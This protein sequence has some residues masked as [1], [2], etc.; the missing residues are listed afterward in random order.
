[1]IDRQWTLAIA[2]ASLA[3]ILPSGVY[4]RQPYRR[5]AMVLRHTGR[6]FS[7][8][9]KRKPRWPS[10]SMRSWKTATKRAQI[11]CLLWLTVF[12]ALP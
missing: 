3:I 5:L 9:R 7:T 4:N 1:V 11:L 10:R 6:G 12:N 8:A 2:D